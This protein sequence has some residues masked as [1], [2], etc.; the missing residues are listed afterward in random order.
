MIVTMEQ[1]AGYVGRP[2]EASEWVT[3]DQARIN[4]FAD[5]TGDH[6]FIHVDPVAARATPLGTTIAHGYLT[7]SLLPI[8][9][10]SIMLRPAN[11]AWGLNYGIDRLRFISPVP[12][13]SAV[14]A[15]STLRSIDDKGADRILLRSDVTVAVR[16]Q[17]K[18][19]LAA[20]TLVFWVLG[21]KDAASG[22]GPT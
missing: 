3:I 12:A 15:S 13:G 19:A 8:L 11:A 16:G 18:P 4:G 14:R 10:G 22:R 9:L 17:D 7:L 6:Q 21:G 20:V 1:L 5:L 2:L